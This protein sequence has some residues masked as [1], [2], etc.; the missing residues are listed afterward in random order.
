MGVVD[1]TML[2]ACS[3]LEKHTFIIYLSDHMWNPVMLCYVRI[4]KAVF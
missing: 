3:F 1:N 4:L 2:Q